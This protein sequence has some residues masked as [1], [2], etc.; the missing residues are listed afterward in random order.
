MISQN[1]SEQ[2]KKFMKIALEEAKLAYEEG[3][4]P[5]GA[6]LTIDGEIVERAHNL[7]ETRGD[8]VSHAEMLLY[9][10]NS[11]KIKKSKKEGAHI[12]MYTTL[13]PCLMCFGA[14]AIHRVDRIVASSP[15]PYGNMS[16]IRGEDLGSF[17]K[18]NLPKIE[19]GLLFNETHKITKD[20][21][22]KKNDDDSNELIRILDS[23]ERA[24]GFA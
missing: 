19:Y 10:S 22:Q 11:A 2:D 14:A 21:L 9:I 18:Q 24:G 8:R 20:Y 1:F 16:A 7:K 6:V 12:T 13:E 4:Y 15:D 5:C 23:I 17:Y 3:N